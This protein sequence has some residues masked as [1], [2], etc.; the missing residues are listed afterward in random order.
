MSNT[1]SFIACQSGG[2]YGDACVRKDWI[3]SGQS[4]VIDWRMFQKF[5]NIGVASRPIFISDSYKL[6]IEMAKQLND[7]ATEIQMKEMVEEYQKQNR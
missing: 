3:G 2:Y 1:N 6:C 7:S 4:F 5:M